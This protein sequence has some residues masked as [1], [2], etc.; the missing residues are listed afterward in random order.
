[1]NSFIFEKLTETIRLI[2]FI[3]KPRTNASSKPLYNPSSPP[4][5]GSDSTSTAAS[6]SKAND[7]TSR[8]IK[9]D[10]PQVKTNTNQNV[11]VTKIVVEEAKGLLNDNH[12][13]NTKKY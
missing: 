2:I 5:G 11:S 8:L 1:M 4:K 6:S 9:R 12:S 13:T 3:D 10:A 7:H